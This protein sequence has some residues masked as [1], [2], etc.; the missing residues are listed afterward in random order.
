MTTTLPQEPANPVLHVIASGY[1]EYQ[2]N[3]IESTTASTYASNRHCSVSMRVRRLSGGRLLNTR[4]YFNRLARTHA[5][6]MPAGGGPPHKFRLV[7]TAADA[8]SLH[9]PNRVLSNERLAATVIADKRDVYY[10][11]GVRLKGSF[12]GRNV[13]RVGFNIAFPPEQLFRGVH[14]CV[15]VDRPA[16]A[17]IGTRE[18]LAKH[19]MNAAGGIPGMYDDLARFIHVLPGYNAV[20]R[21][22]MA[23]FGDAYLASAFANGDDGWMFEYEVLRSSNQTDDGTP[24]GIKLPDSPYVNLDLRDYVPDPE[25]YRWL[26]PASNRMEDNL[27]PAVAV[28]RMFELSGTALANAAAERLDVNQ[29]LRAMA[30]QS[31]LGVGDAIF[32]GSNIH[33]IRF[34]V[35][36]HDG[37]MLY[38]PW[39]W[40]GC[41]QNSTSAPLIGS[42]NV[43]KL[44]TATPHHS[45][46]YLHHLHDLLATSYQTGYMSRWLQHYGAVSGENHSSAVPLHPGDRLRGGLIVPNGTDLT[47]ALAAT[48][49]NLF[50][51]DPGGDVPHAGVT[52]RAAAPADAITWSIAGNTLEV[53]QGGF[54]I[55]YDH[56]L[57]RPRRPGQR[58]HLRL[59]T[60]PTSRF[61]RTSPAARTSGKRERHPG[62]LRRE[63][64]LRRHAAGRWLPL[65]QRQRR[66]GGHALRNRQ[67]DG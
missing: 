61:P 38:M 49:V 50:I 33:N 66:N 4:L 17:T 47:A 18:I 8:A 41:F 13:P 51:A 29:W 32:T 12:V 64:D 10:N 42:G 30:C 35:R 63:H 20:C 55:R 57:R 6:D 58:C 11:V 7:M 52:Y 48:T 56:P 14:D 46:T 62:D 27:A 2:G 34:F 44:V 19:I 28:S 39:D 16:H 5:L 24:T 22:R 43:A 59:P 25:T 54:P 31:P 21:L 9:A 26:W 3:Q 60:P 40:D 37:R 65:R 15:A 53:L 1:T 36:P 23:G 45:R 67:P